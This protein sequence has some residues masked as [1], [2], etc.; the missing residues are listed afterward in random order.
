MT[1]IEWNPK[2]LIH[3]AFDEDHRE[4][5]EL[6]NA[7]EAMAEHDPSPA[8]SAEAVIK[9]LE[10]MKTHSQEEE[11]LMHKMA[12]TRLIPHKIEHD[13]FLNELKDFAYALSEGKEIL[14]ED[15]TL[16]IRTWVYEH[17]MNID[18]AF[19]HW[20]NKKGLLQD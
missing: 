6:V 13:H 9:L 7:I 14:S 15:S 17:I 2:L 5:V 3:P 19:A 8:K 11:A 4:L 10:R 18:K 16:F 1:S 20:L 12:Y